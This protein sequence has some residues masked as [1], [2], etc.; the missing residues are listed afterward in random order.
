MTNPSPSTPSPGPDESTAGPSTLRRILTWLALG[1]GGLVVL[2]V[3]LVGFVV[4]TPSG[5][6]WALD[7]GLARSPVPASV[8]GVRGTLLGPLTLEGIQVDFRGTRTRVERVVLD[9]RPTR[10]LGRTVHVDSLFVSGVAATVP[11]ELEPAPEPAEETPESAGPPEIPQLPVEIRVDT[12]RIEVARAE[13]GERALLEPSTL[14]GSGSLESLHLEARLAGNAAPL[15]RFGARATLDGAPEAY[16]L[17][18]DVELSHPELPPVTATL[19]A[20]GSLTELTLEEARVRTADGEAVLRGAAAWYPEISWDLDARADGLA[21]A[22]F[23]PDPDEWPGAVSFHLGT[24]GRLADAGPEA[25]AV[26][27]ELSG[28]LRNQPLSGGVDVR[29]AAGETGPRTEPRVVATLQ[30][31]DVALDSL[32][33]QRARGEVDVDLAPGSPS[34]IDLR[35][36]A[37]T[38]GSTAVDS[39]VVAGAGLRES[40]RLGIRG[41]MAEDR[42]ALAL[43]G[44]LQGGGEAGAPL[45]WEGSLDSLEVITRLAG[46]WALERPAP[47][48]AAA[49][50]ASLGEACLVQESARACLGGDWASTGPA[51]GALRI[52]A[53]P[54]ALLGGAAPEGIALDGTLEGNATFGV[55]PDGALA[56]EGTFAATGGIDATAGE[57]A[58]RFGLEGQGLRFTIDESGATA[59]LDVALTPETGSGD[60]RASGEIRLPEM[61]RTPVIPREQALEGR[62]EAGSEDLSFL[63]AF[64]PAVA[65]AA[66]RMQLESTLSGTLANPEV[67]GSVAVEEARLDVPALGLELR[68]MTLRARGDPGGEITMDVNV[69]SG[70]GALTVAGRTPALPSPEAPARLEI[71]GQEFRA[72]NTTE[73]K[74]EIAPDLQVSFDGELTTVRGRLA[75]PWARIELVELPE[76]AVRS[77]PDVVFVGEEPAPLPQVD[78][79]VDVV[80]GD[81]V[82][83]EGMGFSSDVRGD[84]QVIQ[85]PAD[86]PLLQGEFELVDGRYA[87]Y[88]QNLDVESGRII[89]AGAPLDAALDVTAER[90]AQD[91]TRAGVRVTGPALTPTVELTSDPALSDADVLSYIM[92]GRSLSDGDASQ[93]EQVVGAAA[94]LGANVLT[95]QLAGSV[96]LDEARIEGTSRETAELVAGK[97]LSPSVFVSYGRGLFK[98]TNTFRIKYL[99]SSS[100]ALQAESGES[101]GGDIL[102]QI[103]RGR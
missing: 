70:D 58:V 24:R 57:Q 100:W 3:L 60:V 46:D 37:L 19:A 91:G 82:H 44:G 21:V 33:L 62:F 97:Y 25:T 63:A 99:L 71:T 1:L 64:A 67:L 69:R 68:D 77:S 17:D 80:V 39:V 42:L 95:T 84:V 81:D 45:L 89:L 20:A 93:Q 59:Q 10:L 16:R 8:E 53:L 35:A 28:S 34:R 94:N 18:A 85:A 90:L 30:A 98:P 15:E 92:Y 86:D 50:S 65:D 27:D 2:V 40:H 4:A 7:Q 5:A 83:F 87:A 56:G 74:V 12:F 9:W 61:N 48:L 41:W 78:A 31:D 29:T 79:R 38:S 11:E 13:V 26:V 101:N 22:A 96:G 49:D 6:R 88:G 55:G 73:I 72:L 66:G 75:V 47:L 14:G 32:S 76:S 51:R 103:E 52:E 23:T 102:Y 54:L 36:T 43:A